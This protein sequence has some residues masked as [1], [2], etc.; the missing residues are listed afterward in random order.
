MEE[1]SIKMVIPCECPHCGKAI[2]VNLNMPHPTADIM[3][4]DEVSPEI[5]KI[6]ENQND[7]PKE[8]EVA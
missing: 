3:T 4:Q 7:Y 8:P 5:K 6:I 2:V 1:D